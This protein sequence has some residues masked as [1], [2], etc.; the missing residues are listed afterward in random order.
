MI[1]KTQKRKIKKILGSCYVAA[2]KDELKTK[3]ALNR[4]GVAYSSTQITNVMNG[5][6][7]KIIEAAIFS[8]TQ[9]QVIAN[10]QLEAQRKIVLKV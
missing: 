5:N 6:S 8:A 10:Q 3:G 7:H 9:K 4:N 1:S 2:V